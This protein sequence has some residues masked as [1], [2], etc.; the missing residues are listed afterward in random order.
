MSSVIQSEI[1]ESVTY[2]IHSLIHFRTVNSLTDASTNNDEIVTLFDTENEQYDDAIAGPSMLQ[3]SASNCSQT[4][5]SS[6]ASL[7]TPPTKVSQTS[8]YDP[9][10]TSTPT[11]AL[12]SESRVPARTR[13]IG[14]KCILFIFL[15]CQFFK[16]LLEITF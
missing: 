15:L 2:M 3:I 5:T 1:E 13:A 11:K 6:Y 9:S 8:S 10:W 12:L 4:S 7:P 16:L 14:S